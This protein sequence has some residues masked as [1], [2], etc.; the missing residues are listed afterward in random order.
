MLLFVLI[1]SGSS[2]EFSSDWSLIVSSLLFKVNSISSR[3]ASALIAVPFLW[4]LIARIHSQEWQTKCLSNHS[5]ILKNIAIQF[6]S[7]LCQNYERSSKGCRWI[8]CVCQRSRS[9]SFSSGQQL[10]KLHPQLLNVSVTE[11]LTIIIKASWLGLP[12]CKAQIQIKIHCLTSRTNR[13]CDHLPVIRCKS[14]WPCSLSS[15]SA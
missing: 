3:Y 9:N 10:R 7:M 13:N 14:H 5:A 6:E 12:S 8:H 15:L 1:S 4:I 2:N 11:C